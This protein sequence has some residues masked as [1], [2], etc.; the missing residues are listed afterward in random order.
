MKHDYHWLTKAKF[1]QMSYIQQSYVSA[2]DESVDN[3]DSKS[4][5]LQVPVTL[6]HEMLWLVGLGKSS[7]SEETRICS[8]CDVYLCIDEDGKC[9]VKYHTDIQ[10]CL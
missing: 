9:F 1:Q 8:Y 7:H 10:Y 4:D 6:E 5:C 2:N 3:I